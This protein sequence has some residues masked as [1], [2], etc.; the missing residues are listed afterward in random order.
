MTIQMT[1]WMVDVV[2]KTRGTTQ[3]R[4]KSI[5]GGIT[6][7]G[8]GSVTDAIKSNVKTRMDNLF[9]AECVGGQITRAVSEW[10]QHDVKF[11]PGDYDAVVFVI[12]DPSASLGT[13]LGRP[14]T[15]AL[16]SSTILGTTFLSQPGGDLA[17]VYFDRCLND[18]ALCN[19]IFHE[20]G[21]LK[22]NLDDPMHKFSTP[23]VGGKGVRV[24]AGTSYATVLPSWDDIDFFTQYISR[25]ATF[26]STVPP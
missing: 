16:A 14:P 9:L 25:K 15:K 10:R 20:A 17:E 5:M 1:L 3:Q 18:D 22:S 24:L 21:H 11:T 19:A 2:A 6:T 7:R 26:R 13:T 4:P 23:G 8:G 12:T